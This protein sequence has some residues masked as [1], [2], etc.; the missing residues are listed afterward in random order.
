MSYTQRDP[1]VC[2]RVWFAEAD[3]PFRRNSHQM[4]IPDFQ[5]LMLPVLQFAAD[6]KEHSIRDAREALAQQFGLS[7]TER[8]ELL[9]SGQQ[10][11]FDN[12]V[13]WAKSYL[14]QAGVLDSL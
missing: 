7:E 6:G 9:P 11:V 4:P 8:K 5:T 3:F 14:Q 10:S 1:K 12:R 13:A 2:F